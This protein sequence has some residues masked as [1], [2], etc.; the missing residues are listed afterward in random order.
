MNEPR[1]P[2][3]YA[4]D[5]ERTYG[6]RLYTF[7]TSIKE[8][9]KKIRAERREAEQPEER[10]RRAGLRQLGADASGRYRLLLFN[11]GLRRRLWRRLWRRRDGRELRCRGRHRSGLSHA[12]RNNRHRL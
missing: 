12:A 6:Q 5:T 2:A 11:D 8:V 3:G 10:Q 7:K 1:P 4:G 9:D